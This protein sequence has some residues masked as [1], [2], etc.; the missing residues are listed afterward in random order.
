MKNFAKKFKVV[1]LS[2]ALIFTA[3]NNNSNTCAHNYFSQWLPPASCTEQVIQERHCLNCNHTETQTADI[4]DHIPGP[5]A[6]CTNA[7]TCLHCEYEFNPALGHSWQWVIQDNI[8]KKTCI[9]GCAEVKNTIR[10]SDFFGNWVSAGGLGGDIFILEITQ[11]NIRL[12]SGPS[13]FAPYI[14]HGN[15]VWKASLN[16][17]TERLISGMPEYG[18]EGI[19]TGPNSNPSI[20]FPLGFTINAEYRSLVLWTL[21]GHS[22]SILPFNFFIALSTDGQTLYVASSSSNYNRAGFSHADMEDSIFTRVEE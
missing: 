11:G 2:L 13:I 14:E 19:F 3:C 21:N 12:Q 22:A 9:N 8:H 15:I 17:A 5:E 20:L 16:T 1:L 10:P 7:Q 6:D 4:Q 18:Y